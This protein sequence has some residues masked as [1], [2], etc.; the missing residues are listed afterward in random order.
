MPFTVIRNDIIK[1][2]ADAIVNTANP[3]PVYGPGTDGAIYRAAGAEALL[4]ERKKIGEIAVGSAAVTGAFALDARYIIHTVGPVWQDGKHHETEQLRSCY[5]ECLKI[6]KA[7]DCKSIV[8]PLISSGRYG[9]PKDLAITAATSEIYEFLMDNDM[10][11]ILSVFDS[12]AYGLST[13][14]FQD[15]RQYIDDNY[16]SEKMN[17]PDIRNT[18]SYSDQSLEGWLKRTESTFSEYLLELIIEKDMKNADVYHGANIT[19]QHFSKLISSKSSHPTKNTVCALA[20][21]LHLDISQT[22]KLLSKAGYSLS[23]S[24][25]FDLAVEYMITHQMYNIVDDNLILYE[26]DLEM[27]GTL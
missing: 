17:Q 6:A 4:A 21:S 8:F 24:S 10:D 26:N 3:K 2:R 14:L 27:L 15:V 13:R 22:R 12:Q 9:F 20:V 1:V 25:R 18:I 19:R 23:S 7:L 11:I 5:R 16:V